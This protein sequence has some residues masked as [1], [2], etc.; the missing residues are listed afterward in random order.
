MSI[1]KLENSIGGVD[2]YLLDQILKKRYSKDAVILDAGCGE[3]RN[4][5]WFY[6]NNIECFGVDSNGSKI[7]IAKSTYT[8]Q[9]AHFSI[10][11]LDV[12]NFKN[13]TFD[14]VICNAVL[15]FAQNT[16]HFFNML[17]ELIRVL[18]PGGSIFIRMTSN[19]GIEKRIKNVGDGI[20]YL[21]D[22]TNRFLITPDLVQSLLTKFPISFLEP[23]KTVNVNNMRSMSTML[24]QKDNI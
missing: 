14:H 22:N 21:P 13:D 16:Q 12:L 2:I 10:Q 1:E 3:G 6:K 19:I 17:S 24:L 7:E 4:L 5:K 9:A 18:K 20:Y 15:H 11:N 8:K 23:L